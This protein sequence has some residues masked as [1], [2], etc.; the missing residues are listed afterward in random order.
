MFVIF[1][2]IVYSINMYLIKLGQNIEVNY[3][4]ERYVTNDILVHQI[5]IMKQI[6]III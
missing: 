6:I 5:S 3:N 2:L 1:T 4:T